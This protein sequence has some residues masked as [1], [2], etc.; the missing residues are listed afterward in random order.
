RAGDRIEVARFEL[1]NPQVTAS[2]AGVLTGLDDRPAFDG[3]I[4]VAAP[5]L[6]AFSGL[7][8]RPLAGTL[9]ARF[10]GVVAADLSAIDAVLS[11]QA[12]GLDLGLP[13]SPG[14]PG[15]TTLDVTA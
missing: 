11:A 2:G 7:A 12:Q 9:D 3:R 8:R 15:D 6:A 10:E 13:G 4:A 1:A 14:F 5:D